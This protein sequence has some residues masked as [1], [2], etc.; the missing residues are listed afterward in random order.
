M[1]MGLVVFLFILNFV[2]SW[3]NAW[4]VGKCWL[5]SKAAGGFTHFVTWCG[6]IM[7]ASGF[8][9]CY[10]IL[11]AIGATHVPYKGH[12]LLT[13]RYA[14]AV[15]ELGYLVVILPIAGSG[16]GILI[17]SWQNFMRSRSLLDGGIAGYNTFANVYNIYNASRAVPMVLRDLGGLLGK[18]KD[19]DSIV[20][21]LV[22]LAALAGAMTTF[23]IVQASAHAK[24]Y[25]VNYDLNQ[26]KADA[27]RSY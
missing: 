2:I 5:E 27:L 7:S 1:N 3:F 10:T 25:K 12:M 6:A 4:S 14:G 20:Y 22:I 16:I 17:A 15:L 11:L 9:W 21:L 19:K 26:H 24:A 23:A 8:T 13:P 18:D